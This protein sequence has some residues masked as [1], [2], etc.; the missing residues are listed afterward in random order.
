MFDMNITNDE[1]LARHSTMRLGGLAKQFAIATSKEELKQLVDYAKTN[2][3]TCLVIGSGSNI[4]WRDQGFDGLLIENKILGFN[5]ETIDSLSAYVT[6]GA[7]ENWDTIVQKCCELGYSGIETLSLVPGS[8]GATP[9]QNVGAYGQEISETLVSLE[10]LDS[11]SNDFII[12]ENKDCRFAYRSS[13]FK[14]NDRGRFFI[15]S[16]KLKLTKKTIAPPF[17]SALDDYLKK[18]QITNYSP[19]SIRQAVIAIRNSKLPDPKHVNN[20]GSFFANPIIPL[21]QFQQLDNSNNMPHWEV[22]EDK[23]KVSAAWLISSVGFKDYHDRETGMATWAKQPLVVVNESA[24][25]TDD[26]LTFKQKIVSSIHDKY[27][28]TLE[29]EPELLP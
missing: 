6:V 15:T 19:L 10:A 27:G 3:L 8:A 29:Q 17:Y 4:V 11:L 9:I 25:S 21:T 26:L 22:A 18:N 28:I 24:K 5:I 12:I 7:G 14:T 16:I 23:I 20:C 2:Y 1:S 13:R